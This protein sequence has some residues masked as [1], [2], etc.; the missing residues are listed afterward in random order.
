VQN[1]AGAVYGLLAT[2]ALLAAE[3]GRHETYLDTV[4]SAVIAACVFWLLHSYANL[5]GRRLE[6]GER[7]SGR[8]LVQALLRD[9]AVLRGASIPLGTLLLAWAAGASQRTGV[10]LALWSAV[11]GLVAFEIMAAI[12][13]RA[14]P[15]ELALEASVGL[16]MGLAILGLRI[17][18][19]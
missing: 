5:L 9:R 1:P 6:G 17:L 15:R 13:T 7:L 8:A 14:T 11:V 3:S 4:L 2:G 18:L 16:A 10:L 12:R 19:H